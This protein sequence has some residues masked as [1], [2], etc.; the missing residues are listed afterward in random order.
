METNK[1]HL[2]KWEIK[3][4]MPIIMLLMSKRSVGKEFASLDNEPNINTFSWHDH[5]RVNH[6]PKFD[7][8]APDQ[9][10]HHQR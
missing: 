1:S 4:S 3:L 6:S 5:Q 8:N 9:I 2:N 7:S 10:T